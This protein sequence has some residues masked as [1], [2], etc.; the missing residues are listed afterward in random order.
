M[1]KKKT[2]KSKTVKSMK[3]LPQKAIDTKTAQGVRGGS[4]AAKGGDTPTESVGFN[5]GKI[6][7]KY[8]P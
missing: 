6:E 5:Y 3:N 4:R 2:R 7:F 8:T 1:D